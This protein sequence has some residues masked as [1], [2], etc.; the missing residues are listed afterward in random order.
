M[1]INKYL[2]QFLNFFLE[3]DKLVVK[4]GAIPTL[5]VPVKSHETEPVPEGRRLHIVRDIEPKVTEHYKRF[6]DF[7]KK[8]AKLKLTGWTVTKNDECFHFKF[9]K[10]P[11]SIPYFELMVNENLLFIFWCMVGH[12]QIILHYIQIMIDH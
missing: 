11:Y 12:Y 9:F 5:N 8:V 1:Y 6:N 4:F 3:N 10:K 7:E 2:T